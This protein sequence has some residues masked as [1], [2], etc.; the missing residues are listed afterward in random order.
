MLPKMPPRE[1]QLGFL[2][3]PPYRVQGISV[4]G[5]QT[6]IQI[7]ELDVVFD[8]GYCTRSSL[9]SG[10]VALTH[11][12]MDHVGA[13]PYWFSQ[14]HFQK[15]GTGRVVCHP[16]IAQPL[17]RMMKSWVDLEQQVTPYEIV[18]LA[19]GEDLHLKANIV[20]RAFETHHTA[21]SLAY[22]IIEK[23]S[24]L[25]PEF[26]DS[27]Q[28][29]IRELKNKGVEITTILEIPLIAFTGDTS[30]CPTLE[31]DEFVNAR[32]LLTECTFFASEH[33]DRARVGRHLHFSDLKR[34]LEIWK[35]N[36][37][38]VTHVSRRTSLSFAR[39][40]I[41]SLYN[42]RY[43]DRVHLLMDYRNNRKRYERQLEDASTMTQETSKSS[44]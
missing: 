36:H 13:I 39:N 37:I 12:H 1:G 10:T 43:R 44:G 22:A 31:C 27:P 32:I 30:Y 2:Y 42:G 34:L 16:S 26:A 21:P 5:E 24:K 14:R 8:M 3:L 33:Q 17:D 23:R 19:P 7:P 15:L 35:A 29:H 11:A 6:T 40:E 38:V 41:D 4:A 28:E 20:L 18:P 9:S 25:K